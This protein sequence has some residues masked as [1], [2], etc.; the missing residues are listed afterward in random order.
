MRV[1]T[2]REPAW[3]L[4]QICRHSQTVRPYKTIKE[5]IIILVHK[6]ETHSNYLLERLSRSVILEQFTQT[7]QYGH[8]KC[9]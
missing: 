6:R 1:K 5:N 7:S 4:Q 9:P 8:D 3:Q 2:M